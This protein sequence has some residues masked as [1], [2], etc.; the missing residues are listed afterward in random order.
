VGVHEKI[1]QTTKACKGNASICFF[2]CNGI[3]KNCRLIYECKFGLTIYKEKMKKFQFCLVKFTSKDTYCRQ[4]CS[5]QAFIYI[6]GI[7]IDCDS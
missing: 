2:L 6:L 7:F 4:S 5:C 3:L 1:M